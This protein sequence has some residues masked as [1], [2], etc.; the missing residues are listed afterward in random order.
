MV[1]IVKGFNVVSETEV[2]VFLEFPCFLYDLVTVGTKHT[3]SAIP[4]QVHILS[5]L[6]TKS[7]CVLTIIQS[8]WSKVFTFEFWKALSIL[9]MLPH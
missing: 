8:I 7:F 1:H 5:Q 4:S 2:D 6:V 9:Q 3:P